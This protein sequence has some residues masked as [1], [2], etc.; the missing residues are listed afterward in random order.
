MFLYAL[1]CCIKTVSDFA[2]QQLK[3]LLISGS[4]VRTQVCPPHNIEIYEI[5]FQV[6]DLGVID[7][8][9]SNISSN[10]KPVGLCV[11]VLGYS[12]DTLS[13]GLSK[14][15]V[16]MTLPRQSPQT[17]FYGRCSAIVAKA[18]RKIQGSSLVALARQV[19][20]TI[21]SI[22]MQFLIPIAVDRSVRHS[23]SVE[24]R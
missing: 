9:K 11:E 8:G 23:V 12:Y 17:V 5:V 1:S 2:K 20:A 6:S 22:D 4:L 19:R 21:R 24:L 7:F 18:D 10:K 16:S 14:H 15:L 13:A 3:F